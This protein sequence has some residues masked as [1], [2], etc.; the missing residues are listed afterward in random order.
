MPFSPAPRYLSHQANHAAACLEA[1][2]TWLRLSWHS[3]WL[4]LPVMFQACCDFLHLTPSQLSLEARRMLAAGLA[5]AAA[6]EAHWQRQQ[7]WE[8]HYHNRLHTADVLTA[9]ALQLGIE[10]RLS[11]LQ[12]ND[13]LTAGL[14]CAV[15]H[16]F[17]HAG[18]VNILP[19]ELERRSW[20]I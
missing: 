10:A 11:G 12:D 6:S 18:G 15:G 20:K 13:W 8:P 19:C 2:L 3:N 16:D 14:L 1:S 4:G 5:V 9:M 17:M 7:V